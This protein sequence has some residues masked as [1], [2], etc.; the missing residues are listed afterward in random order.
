MRPLLLS[1]LLASPAFA[2]SS[3]N[4]LAVYGELGVNFT[5]SDAF[6]DANFITQGTDT[7][8]IGP[9]IEVATQTLYQTF[10]FSDDGSSLTVYVNSGWGAI[11][12]NGFRFELTDAGAPSFIDA[13]IVSSDYPGFT[14]DRISWL[15]NRLALNFDGL[16]GAGT[17]VIALDNDGGTTGPVPS[18]V[19]AGSC[20]GQVD[21]DFSGFTPGGPIAVLRGSALGW[22]AIP[23][24]PCAGVV[25]DLSG[26]NLVTIANANANG[27]LSVSPRLGMAFCGIDIQ[28]LDVTTCD[29]SNPAELP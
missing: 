16:S 3:L 23:A 9:G 15:D 24:G 11:G 5:T 7:G 12:F 8:I 29:L 28:A 21:I 27:N 20:P 1:V 10:D 14:E 22:D 2:A 18:V 4:G 26:L 25:T 17:I 13:T 6:D 19:A